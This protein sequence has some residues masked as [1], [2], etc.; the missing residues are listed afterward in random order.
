MAESSPD[1][2]APDVGRV[3]RRSSA[4]GRDRCDVPYAWPKT[5]TLPER[6]PLLVYLDMNHWIA[7]AKAHAG[8]RDGRQHLESLDGLR[9]ARDDGRAIFP[10]SGTILAE[11]S[12]IGRY[13]QRRTL[14]E[15]IEA[16]SGYF[17]VTARDI[18]ATHEVEEMLD[19]VAGPN[20]QPVNEM[21]YLDWGIARAF[22][23]VGG[24]R[25]RRKGDGADI[26]DETRAT[27]PEG[28]AD[29][30]QRLAEAELE[31]Q[32]K[33]LDVPTPEEEPQL[34]ALG[35]KPHGA[36]EVTD[37]RARQ[38]LEQ[39]VRF[40]A[41][42]QWRRGR[43]RDVVASREIIIEIH[44]IL[45]RGLNNRGVALGDVFDSPVTTRAHFDAMPSFDVA[46]TLKTAYHRDPQHRWTT[47][48]IHD[49]DALGSTLPY[50][51]IVVTDKA[52]ADKARK[53]GLGARL[54]TP[55]LHS[56]TGL[57]EALDST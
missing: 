3:P 25:I 12:K 24:F 34:R 50:C 2:E 5:M 22:G 21:N 54:D 31:L 27:W 47:N 23:M 8:H 19:R 52:V 55:V 20:P 6:P 29:F 16:L 10:I 33:V 45:E 41:D 53:S 7:L 44:G 40:D 57:V 36:S 1:A 43:V 51:D 48:D 46:V 9:R 32:R 26:T 30:D 49:I 39:V 4:A 14:R 42:P 37:N 17:V 18:I 11:V 15:I 38:E 35:W 13:Q 56:L 28:A